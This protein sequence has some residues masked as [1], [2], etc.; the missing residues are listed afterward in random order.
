MTESCQNLSALRPSIVKGLSY[1]VGKLEYVTKVFF[2]ADKP[3]KTGK[4]PKDLHSKLDSIKKYERFLKLFV[5]LD[6]EPGV[7]VHCSIIFRKAMDKRKINSRLEDFSQIFAACFF[8]S[9]K[10][11]TDETVCHLKEYAKFVSLEPE[12]LQELEWGILTTILKFD[13]YVDEASFEKEVQF[14]QAQSA[15]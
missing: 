3:M 8:L 12:L 10:Y 1:W 4:S 13:L 2:E 15:L 7:M 11:I 14:L 9:L 5:K 6:I